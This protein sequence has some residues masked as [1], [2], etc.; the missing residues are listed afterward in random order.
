[1]IL[2]QLEEF[3]DLVKEIEILE[4]RIEK[5]EH[6][7]EECVSDTV[8]AASKSFPYIPHTVRI[9]GVD[10]RKLHKIRRVKEIL[11]KRKDKLYRDMEE[12]DSFIDN[13]DESRIRQII[14]L[15]Y[16][17]GFTWNYI[18]ITR[19]YTLRLLFFYVII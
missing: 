17:K 1:M 14:T 13:V 8:K 7:T 2:K 4:Q 5:L 10:V 15:R 12:V 19:A 16:I 3:R 6:E 9:T 11:N 18:P